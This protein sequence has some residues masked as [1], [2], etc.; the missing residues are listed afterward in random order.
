MLKSCLWKHYFQI[1]GPRTQAWDPRSEGPG[2]GQGHMVG[3]PWARPW[4]PRSD[5]WRRSAAASRSYRFLRFLD[6]ARFLKHFLSTHPHS[7]GYDSPLCHP[8]V[9]ATAAGP[10]HQRTAAAHCSSCTRRIDCTGRIDRTGRMD[11][12]GRIGGT[13]YR[14][15]KSTLIMASVI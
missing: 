10:L 12:T 15:S 4:G 6:S 7:F 11:C 14:Q 5:G 3:R 8:Y 2:P 1:R 13:Y 9:W